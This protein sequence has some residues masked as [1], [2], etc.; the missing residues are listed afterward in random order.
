MFQIKGF[1]W[2][3]A[4]RVPCILFAPWLP[5]GVIRKK[6]MHVVDLLPT[7]ISLAEVNVTI[8]GIIDGIDLSNMIKNETGS[9]RNEIVTI[10]Q[11]D[12][13]SSLINKGYK[14]VNGS[15]ALTDG[16]PNVWLGTNDNNQYNSA[17]YVE[18]VQK[19]KVAVS[20]SKFNGPL[21]PSTITSL[22]K[23]LIVDCVG[24]KTPCNVQQAPCLF[25]IE[26]DPCEEINLASSLP[27]LYASMK[28]LLQQ[29]VS[30]AVPSRIKNSGE[31][32][33]FKQ[34]YSKI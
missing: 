33:F 29:H 23:N 24:V 7:L 4:I 10:D 25:D 1:G 6:F 34:K 9:F 31:F 5:S 8:D 2:E 22:R 3:G 27:D 30:T 32:Y 28:L 12:G 14:L 16:D 26:S 18:T 11:I 13:V 21:A 20:L 17:Q 15:Q 19:S